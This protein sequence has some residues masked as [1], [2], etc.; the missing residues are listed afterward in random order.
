MINA[1]DK[2]EPAGSP[3]HIARYFLDFCFCR[4]SGN[5]LSSAE[6]VANTIRRCR[7][8]IVRGKQR[9]RWLEGERERERTTDETRTNRR[10]IGGR[11]NER[12]TDGG[13]DGLG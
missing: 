6:V 5:A 13:D 7:F 2:T 3:F 10:F 8:D 1:S 4:N 12:G 11:P 9:C